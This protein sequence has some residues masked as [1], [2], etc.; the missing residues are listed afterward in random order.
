MNR[1]QQKPRL[2]T[3]FLISKGT[4]QQQPFVDRLL[5]GQHLQPVEF[6]DTKFDLLTSC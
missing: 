3:M 2:L 6:I 1:K 4:S 5:T